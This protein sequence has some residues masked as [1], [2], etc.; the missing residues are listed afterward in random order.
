[1]A[2][3]AFNI[4]YSTSSL[5]GRSFPLPLPRSRKL[6]RKAVQKTLLTGTCPEHIFQGSEHP[7]AQITEAKPVDKGCK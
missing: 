6:E 3:A 5:R 4:T 1:M 2:R 7:P